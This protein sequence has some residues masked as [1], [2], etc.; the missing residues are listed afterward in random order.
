MRD[1]VNGL[2][3]RVAMSFENLPARGIA[4]GSQ[5]LVL[6]K[7]RQ[8]AEHRTTYAG[9]ARQLDLSRV[10]RVGSAAASPGDGGGAGAVRRVLRAFLRAVPR[11]VLRLRA[12]PRVPD[13]P[14]RDRIRRGRPPPAERRLP[15]PDGLLPRRRAALRPAARPRAA[16]PAG[17]LVEGARLRH[18]RAGEAIQ[19]VH[20]VRA[21][22]A[23]K[24]HGR[25]AVQR[26]PLRRRRR[27]VGGQDH[28][29][30]AGCTWPRRAR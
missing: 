13:Q 24:L 18:P 21:R 14:A 17:R 30:R 12:R 10:R 1:F 26:V 27:H 3:P 6:W 28:A 8:F 16:A 9:N 2:R 23:A 15:Q 7:D 11:H 4:A 22:G 19:A 29:A 5:S 25:R 20:L